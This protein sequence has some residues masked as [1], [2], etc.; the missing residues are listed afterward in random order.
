MAWR[1]E[2]HLIRGE[3]DNR[4]RGR[5]TGRLWFEGRPE[6]VT[7]ELAGNAWRDLAGRVLR[8]ANPTTKTAG[9]GALAGLATVQRGV[10]GDITA[11][12]KV[13]VPDCTMDELRALLREKKDFPWHWGNSLYLE[14]HG[15]ENGRVVIEAAHYELALDAAAAW[16]MSES[17]EAVQRE[18]NGRALLDFMERL[19][20]AG[21]RRIAEETAL[22]G[23]GDDDAPQSEAEAAADAEQA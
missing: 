10:T 23:A 12:R 18:A 5:V 1:I 6:P 17:E 4:I 15:E 14:W 21:E 11:S 3:I 7:L 9:P 16:T 19:G 20:R 22:G 13:K 2:E 8:F